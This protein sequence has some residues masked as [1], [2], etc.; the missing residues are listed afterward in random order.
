LRDQAEESGRK[1]GREERRKERGKEGGGQG[2]VVANSSS[3][4]FQRS[5]WIIFR[6]A[7]LSFW[8]RGAVRFHSDS[9]AEDVTGRL[10]F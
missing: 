6:T 4:I 9:V 10:S 1:E 7:P 3:S 2:E 8:E 5:A